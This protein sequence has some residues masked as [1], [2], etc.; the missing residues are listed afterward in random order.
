MN[1]FYLPLV[2]A[3]VFC[4]ASSGASEVF[5]KLGES[6]SIGGRFVT[7]MAIIGNVVWLL[8]IAA[9]FLAVK[10]WHVPIL[11][12]ISFAG[13]V[14]YGWVVSMVGSTKNNS[15]MKGWLYL[16]ALASIPLLV[17]TIIEMW[18]AYQ[19]M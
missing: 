8:W 9:F 6:K 7:I 18:Y 13:T 12:A 2:L 17:W 14:V 1:S 5:E 16:S 15:L 3:S 4:Y 11:F 10:W 19:A